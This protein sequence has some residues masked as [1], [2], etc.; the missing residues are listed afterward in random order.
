MRKL[1]LAIGTLLVLVAASFVSPVGALAASSSHTA[2]MV[3]PHSG[4]MSP[5]S[6]VHMPSTRIRSTSSV[7][8]PFSCDAGFHFVASP[9]GPPPNFLVATSAINAGDIWAVGNSTNAG[10]Y[11]QT[12]AM[13]WNGATW[14]IVPTPNLSV[15]H[16]DFNAVVAIST[17]DV[18][19]VG[20]YWVDNAGTTNTFAEHWD[21]TV[22]T[23]FTLPSPSSFSFLFGVT[24]IASNNVW[25]VGTWVNGSVPETLVEQ[26]NGTSWTQMPSSNPSTQDNELF[27]VSAFSATDVF[28]VGEQS[29]GFGTPLQSLAQHWN[30]TAWTDLTTPNLGGTGADNEIL[31]VNAL[32]AGHAVGVGFGNF[33]SG[34]TPRQGVAWDLLAA[35]ASTET[36]QSGPGTGDNALLAVARSGA[37]LWAVGYWRGTVAGPRETMV[38]PATWNSAT[39]ALT[40]GPMG[41]SES[42]SGINNALLGVTAISPYTFWAAGYDTNG[43]SVNQTLMEAYCAR[44]FSMTGPSGAHGNSAFSVTVTVKNGDG[45]TATSYGGTVHFTSSDG[46]ATLPPNYMYVPADN[47]AHTFSGVV[48]RTAGSQTITVADIAMPFTV[49]AS[50]SVSVCIGLC[51]SPAGAPGSRTTKPGPAGGAGARGAV[52][53]SIAGTPGPR[54]PRLGLSSQGNESAVGAAPATTT[55]QAADVVAIAASTSV[56]SAPAAARAAAA[57][58]SNTSVS[59]VANKQVVAR[60]PAQTPWSLLFFIPLLACALGLIVVRRRTFK[61]KSNA[62]I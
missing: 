61:E 42:P 10:G 16:N 27:S 59:L 25:A 44:N 60:P 50:I 31:G 9:N 36:T 43:A 1:A 62:R 33:V 7:V 53:Q 35:G 2:R 19:A 17:S 56:E 47:G 8:L 46:A 32:E 58:T 34:S 51:Q 3:G 30:G 11:D 14:T 18:W 15:F 57:A 28:V 54:L 39:H 6:L 55:G 40:W 13:H 5:R 41:A 38:F 20:D 12:L 37:G 22:W 49:P 48:L 21:G 45:S 4:A 52:K 29:Q 24:A 23:S 26:W